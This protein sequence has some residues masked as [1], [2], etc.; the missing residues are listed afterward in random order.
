MQKRL[1][2]SNVPLIF[3]NLKIRKEKEVK[4]T[5]TYEVSSFIFCGNWDFPNYQT[6]F[7]SKEGVPKMKTTNKIL[8]LVSAIIIMMTV[9]TFALAD[10]P[11]GDCSDPV[12]PVVDEC[13]GGTCDGG[14]TFGDTNGVL[15]GATDLSNQ[16]LWGAGCTTLEASTIAIAP[17][18]GTASI[19]NIASQGMN[20]LDERADGTGGISIQDFTTGTLTTL[21]ENGATGGGNLF[22]ENHTNVTMDSSTWDSGISATMAGDLNMASMICTTPG[23]TGALDSQ[24]LNQSYQNT[25]NGN[26]ITTSQQWQTLGTLKINLT[27]P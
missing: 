12:T 26:G 21:A 23:T 20:I 16:K 25:D 1:Y 8:T 3:Y 18:I 11:S 10:C 4:N 13:I 7:F 19:T 17:T 5:T 15:W 27:T 2:V 6:Q 24:T 14:A 22:S 9:T